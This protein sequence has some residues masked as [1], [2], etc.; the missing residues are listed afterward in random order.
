MCTVRRFLDLSTAHL[1][2]ELGATGLDETPGAIAHP[3]ATAGSCG[4]RTTPTTP[5]TP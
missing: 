2:H 1:P 3:P 5:P 4:C